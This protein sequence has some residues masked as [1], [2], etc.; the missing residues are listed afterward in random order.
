MVSND[1]GALEVVGTGISRRQMRDGYIGTEVQDFT[2]HSRSG[3]VRCDVRITRNLNG[4]MPRT[5]ERAMKAFD[6]WA[7]W[8]EKHGLPE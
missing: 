8:I 6:H 7:A 3:G 4:R 5:N 1:Y 2:I